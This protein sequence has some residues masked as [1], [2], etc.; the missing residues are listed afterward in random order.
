MG[1]RQTY[2]QESV[3]RAGLDLDC[4]KKI[5]FFSEENHVLGQW[6]TYINTVFKLK[7]CILAVNSTCEK[8]MS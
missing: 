4:G 3:G 1:K 5:F 6:R 8:V 2:Y 7:K